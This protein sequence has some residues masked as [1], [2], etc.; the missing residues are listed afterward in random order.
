VRADRRREY[1]R[2]V[3]NVTHELLGVSLAVTAGR[4]LDAGPLEIAGLAAAAVLGS[5]LPDVDQLGAR[6]HRRMRLER[7]TRLAVTAGACCA[8]PWWRSPWSCRTEP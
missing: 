4:V 6:V 1:R 3:R 7:R 5:R 2:F 8:F